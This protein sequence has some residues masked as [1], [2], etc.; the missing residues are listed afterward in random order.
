MRV[1]RTSDTS[2]SCMRR[3]VH[4]RRGACDYLVGTFTRSRI[5]GWKFCFRPFSCAAGVRLTGPGVRVACSATLFPVDGA[6]V[7]PRENSRRGG[8]FREFRPYPDRTMGNPVF[9][10]IVG[11][12]HLNE[13]PLADPLRFGLPDQRVEP[14]HERLRQPGLLFPCLGAVDPGPGEVERDEPDLPGRRT[15]F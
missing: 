12:P 8:G 7:A 9:A 13:L 2:R 14:L 4:A 5:N 3:D 15:F 10:M 11:L 1:A 6:G